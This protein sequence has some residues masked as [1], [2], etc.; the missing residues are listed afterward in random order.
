MYHLKHIALVLGVV[1][2]S[3]LCIGTRGR[4]IHDLALGF[5]R[6]P[7]NKTY[8]INKKPYNL[9]LE[10]R[11]SF[12]NGVHKLWVF[13]T[14]E[15]HYRGSQTKPRS[16]LS[17]NGYKYSTGVWQFEAHVFVPYGTSGVSLMQVFGASYPHASTL[18]VR[19]YNGD[20]YYYRE[21][22][23]VHDIYNKWFRLNVIHNVE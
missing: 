17:I 19:V 6:L 12:I 10:E 13:S 14:D 3:T 23:I 4:L 5:I 11:Y 2:F 9:P 1:F 16:E 21:K 8:Y 22:V 7:F 20:L 18:M 15:P